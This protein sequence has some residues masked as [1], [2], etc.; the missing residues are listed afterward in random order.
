MAKH[1]RNLTQV[2][3]AKLF[4]HTENET[5]FTMEDPE[6]YVSRLS[7][8][9][10]VGLFSFGPISNHLHITSRWVLS[11]VNNSLSLKICEKLF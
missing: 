7:Q 3:K 8:K 6:L 4:S 11:E 9:L 2:Q 10:G 5:R 1:N